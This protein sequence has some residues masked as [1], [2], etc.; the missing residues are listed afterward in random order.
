MLNK[1]GAEKFITF[2]E[3]F[4]RYSDLIKNEAYSNLTE[5]FAIAEVAR[6][7]WNGWTFEEWNIFC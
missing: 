7:R 3:Y 2:R 1:L 6:V 4:A 5:W